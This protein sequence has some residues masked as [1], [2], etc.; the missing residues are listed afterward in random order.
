MGYL[1][2]FIKNLDIFGAKIQLN[3]RGNTKFS[4][5]FGFLF[6]CACSIVVIITI[7]LFGKDFYN[8]ENPR[9]IYEIIKT[10]DYK[11]INISPSNFTI[12]FRIENH[13]GNP[14][15]DAYNYLSII[16]AQY[17]LIYNETILDYDD[18]F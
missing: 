6:S 4:T 11:E 3:I 16:N 12:A 7:I 8:K 1:N 5:L 13:K 2:S 10:S 15:L 9:L 14:I 17:V 18:S